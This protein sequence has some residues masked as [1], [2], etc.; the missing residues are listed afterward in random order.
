MN[1]L[2][3]PGLGES[4]PLSMLALRWVEE[5]R[6]PCAPQFGGA[7]ACPGAGREELPPACQEQSWDAREQRETEAGRAARGWGAAQ[8]QDPPPFSPGC[9]AQCHLCPLQGMPSVPGTPSPAVTCPC[10]GWF[11][12]SP[13]S[14][15]AGGGAQESCSVR[16]VC[17]DLRGWIT[18]ARSI[19][20]SGAASPPLRRFSPLNAEQMAR[21][22]QSEMSLSCL[23]SN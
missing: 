12:F 22:L 4:P 21:A 18:I 17:R 20:E 9:R 23:K 10:L 3:G 19:A 15:G 5:G 1:L 13:G 7:T 14:G 6:H 2:P 16:G 8:H 11:W